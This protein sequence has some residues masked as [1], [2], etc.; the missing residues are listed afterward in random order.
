MTA[1]RATLSSRSNQSPNPSYHPS[2]PPTAS[3]LPLPLPHTPAPKLPLEIQVI[4]TFLQLE[5]E[6]VRRLTRARQRKAAS[7]EG[8]LGLLRRGSMG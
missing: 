6:E 3:T 2:I 7:Q 8:W 4:A 5:E 1:R